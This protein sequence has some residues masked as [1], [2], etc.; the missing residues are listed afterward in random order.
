[1]AT[2]KVTVKEELV[3]NGKDMGNENFL[4]IAGINSAEHRIIDVA[5][6][7]QSILLFDT[8]VAAGTYAD[9]T[10]KHL[11]ITN[12]DGTNFVQL[13]F[14]RSG[15]QYYAK[16]EPGETFILGNSEMYADATGTSSSEAFGNID[17]IH[18]KANTAACELEVFIAT[19]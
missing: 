10:L 2:L 8:A 11:R 18:A 9:S 7:E 6:A 15:Q 1:M 5:T 16:V 14:V 12:L 13:R 4:S 3:L 17:A 19:T